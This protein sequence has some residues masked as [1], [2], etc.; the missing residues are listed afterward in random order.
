MSGWN[1]PDVAIP[2]AIAQRVPKH[3]VVI[4]RNVIYIGRDIGVKQQRLDLRAEYKRLTIVVVVE[5]LN[6]DAI[7]R[8]NELL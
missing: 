1:L 3:Q 7:A 6:A 2:R 4:D 5:R 8:K